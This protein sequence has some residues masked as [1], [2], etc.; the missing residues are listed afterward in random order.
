MAPV[1]IT[2]PTRNLSQEAVGKGAKPDSEPASKPKAKRQAKNPG[3]TYVSL[4]E[5][6]ELT[7]QIEKLESLHKAKCERE[8]HLEKPASQNVIRNRALEIGLAQLL[9]EAKSW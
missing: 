8:G 6:K 3:L 4:R 9:E 2:A 1:S 5:R 7:E